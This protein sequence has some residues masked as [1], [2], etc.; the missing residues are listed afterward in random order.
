MSINE[1]IVSKFKDEDIELWEES[2]VDTNNKPPYNTYKIINDVQDKEAFGETVKY[3]SLS[4]E[5]EIWENNKKRCNE[6]IKKTD[7]IMSDLGFVRTN[8]SNQNF[9]N[10]HHSTRNY[11]I[12]IEE[13]KKG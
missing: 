11:E 5:I 8:V 12:Y 10:L 3:C 9:L 1:I 6:K 4:Y 13:K 7:K 2:Q